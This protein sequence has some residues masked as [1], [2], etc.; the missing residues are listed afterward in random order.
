MR[1]LRKLNFLGVIINSQLN[2]NDHIQTISNK[3][4]KNVDIIFRK[5]NNLNRN[6]LLM[7]YHSMIQPYLDYCNIVWAAG[8]SYLDHLFKKQKKSIRTITFAK[9]N[10]H[11]DPIFEQ[12]KVLK[13]KQIN[14]FQTCY[15][16]YKSLHNLLSSQFSNFFTINNE[17]HHYNTRAA[18]K[19]HQIQHNL[20]V[21]ARS[22][23][24]HGVKMW[25]S[26]SS[27]VTQS[28]SF[29]IFKKNCKKHIVEHTY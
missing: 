27:A 11:S 18:Y 13:L 26:L 29:N 12:L 8:G 5:R 9:L 25:N 20:N 19:I 10:A 23:R 21:R 16:V 2:W 14:I 28:P 6:T 4:S 22:I 7:L 17:I 24:V 3:I 1:I 15:F